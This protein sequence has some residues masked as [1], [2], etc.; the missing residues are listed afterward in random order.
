[1]SHTSKHFFERRLRKK[2]G[3]AIH[4]YRMIENGDKVLVAISGG[5]DSIVM[6]KVLVA[7]KEA[8][9]LDFELLPVH[10]KTGYDV[11]FERISSWIEENIGYKV[12]IHDGYI[13][14]IMDLVSEPDKSPCALCSRLRRGKLYGLAEEIGATSIALGHHMDDIIETFLLRSFYTG[15]LGAMAPA[16]R[17]DDGKN[18]IIRPLAYCTSELINSYYT[19]IGIEPVEIQCPIRPDSKRKLIRDYIKSIE[20]DIPTIKYSLFAS[21]RNID[22]R[23]LCIMENDHA[24]RN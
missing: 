23:S 22:M 13:S 8:A 21:L 20:N 24:D 7:L 4:D 12:L 18:R 2:V 3:Q 6:L 19:Y 9:P 17:T 1:V 5:K 16:R 10:I 14:Q 15:Q 11:G